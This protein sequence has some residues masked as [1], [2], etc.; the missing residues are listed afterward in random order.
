M[1]NIGIVGGQLQG[2]EAVYL[3]GQA[4][5]KTVLMDKDLPV[6]AAPL[7][8]EFYQIDIMGGEERVRALF[9][10]LDLILPATENHR[11]LTRLQELA[12]RCGVPL[13]LDLPAYDIS[14]SKIESNKLFAQAGIAMPK[15]WPECGFPVIVKPSG[16]SGS[17]GVVKVTDQAQLT[18]VLADMGSDT[19]IQKY[20][21]G[22]SYSLEI[23]AHRG[24]C[25][26]LQVTELEFD[27]GY[28]CKRVLAGP[29]TG[30][31]V[32]EAF[33]DLGERLAGALNLSGIMDIEVIDTGG[34][35]K[36]LEIDARLPS[37]TPTAVFHSSGVNMVELL[38][39]YWINGRLPAYR[40]LTGKSRAVIFEHLKFAGGSLEVAG[41]HVLTGARGLQ[42]YQDKFS[43][44]VLISNF[45]HSPDAWVAT[46]V[47]VENTEAQVWETRNR[48]LKIMQQAFKARSYLDPQP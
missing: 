31:E 22:P 7:A 9:M 27:A 45:T 10:E 15:S 35:L 29:E 38:A 33:C 34:E 42:V 6:P 14:S 26:S 25:T 19:V 46:A 40:R 41:E 1:I 37:Q 16:L 32:A 8:D 4:G 11:T 23:L 44:D 21:P 36:V 12:G 48:A 3:A 28:D 5:F 47:F 17:A 30:G 20:L 43:A 24:K 18:A 2:L 39:D 13:A